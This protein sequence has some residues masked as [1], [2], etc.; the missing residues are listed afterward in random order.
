MSLCKKLPEGF[1][2][3]SKWARYCHF[4]HLDHLRSTAILQIANEEKHRPPKQGNIIVSWISETKNM[5][6]Y[7]IPHSNKYNKSPKRNYLLRPRAQ[8][9][10][11]VT[12]ACTIWN[13]LENPSFANHCPTETIGFPISIVVCWATWAT[14]CDKKHI[15]VDQ[16]QS[17]ANSWVLITKPAEKKVMLCHVSDFSRTIHGNSNQALGTI[18]Q[19]LQESQLTHGGHVFSF[20]NICWDVCYIF[21]GNA[22]RPTSMKVIEEPLLGI[23]SGG[24]C[25]T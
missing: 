3:I 22:D 10:T 23:G 16:G 9:T 19:N 12:L 11:T 2:F 20:I 18:V 17:I 24:S 15:L 25:E 8:Q 7:D 6:S 5:T 13:T 4:T 21:E 1:C 14:S